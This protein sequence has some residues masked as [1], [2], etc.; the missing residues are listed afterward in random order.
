MQSGSVTG[1]YM[2][3]ADYGSGGA[4]LRLDDA[5]TSRA[6]LPFEC[7]IRASETITGKYKV[8]RHGMNIDNTT[9]DYL[10]V[11]GDPSSV[12][13]KVLIDGRIYIIR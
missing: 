11:T 1:A 2:L 12:T 5:S 8:I 4:W 10:P 13:E 9:T 6:I 3:D 7:Y